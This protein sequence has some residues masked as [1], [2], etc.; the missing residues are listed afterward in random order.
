MQ[1]LFLSSET[2]IFLSEG[3]VEGQRKK[4]KIVFCPWFTFLIIRVVLASNK[5]GN[6]ASS[7]SY[8]LSRFLDFKLVSKRFSSWEQVEL[9]IESIESRWRSKLA[10][11]EVWYV[12][13]SLLKV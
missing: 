9:A 13:G 12:D 11:V 1:K 3:V 6:S 7:A 8:G 10:V 5:E 4:R 2:N